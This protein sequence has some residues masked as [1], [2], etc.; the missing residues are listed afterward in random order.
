MRF[1]RCDGPGCGVTSHSTR[2]HYLGP[3]YSWLALEANEDAD[4]G[5]FCSWTCLVAFATLRAIERETPADTPPQPGG[6][7]R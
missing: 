4:H 5:Q 3:D 2:D 7:Q 1:I 6:T